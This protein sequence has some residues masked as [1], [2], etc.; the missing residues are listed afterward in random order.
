MIESTTFSQYSNLNIPLFHIDNRNT[1]FSLQ[2]ERWQA[3]GAASDGVCD[4]RLIST[5]S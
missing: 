2:K 1:F 3:I 4:S 5:I